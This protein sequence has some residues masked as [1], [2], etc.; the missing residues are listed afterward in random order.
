LIPLSAENEGP[1]PK[2]DL[3]GCGKIG[4]R[5]PWQ[6]KADITGKA[7]LCYGFKLG[8]TVAKSSSSV[9]IHIVCIHTNRLVSLLV[10]SSYLSP[11]SHLR[12]DNGNYQ[13]IR[14]INHALC[15]GR[16]LTPGCAELVIED[17]STFERTIRNCRRQGEF[18][19]FGYGLTERPNF[20][21]NIL[22]WKNVST[23]S[24]Q[25]T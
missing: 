13:R 5:T 12:N 8:L 11:L 19:I 23:S 9:N 10:P 6:F 3:T 21:R 14:I 2:Q 7:R 16:F 18:I 15:K 25:P 17:P 4:D 24:K 1:F 20:H 22:N